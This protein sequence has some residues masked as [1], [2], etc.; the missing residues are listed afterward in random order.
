MTLSFTTSRRFIPTHPGMNA[1]ST[2]AIE[3]S[4]FEDLCHQN[5]DPT[6][7]HKFMPAAQ[8][9][10]HSCLAFMPALQYRGLAFE[11]SNFHGSIVSPRFMNNCATAR[12]AE[13]EQI[14]IVISR[15]FRA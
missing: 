10:R 5:N 15:A 13:A 1:Y 11:R 9:S 3:C 6:G 8:W 14:G 2:R 7:V 4:D 12:M